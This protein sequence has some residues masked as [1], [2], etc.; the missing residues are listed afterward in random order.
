MN[1][2][3]PEFAAVIEPAKAKAANDA[4][5]VRAIERAAAGLLDSSNCVTLFA[6]SSRGAILMNGHREYLL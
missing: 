6:D 1:F 4:R 2:N 5:W 3:T